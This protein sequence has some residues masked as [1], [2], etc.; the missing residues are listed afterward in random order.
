MSKVKFTFFMFIFISIFSLNAD[1]HDKEKR[2]PI[3]I[4][5]ALIDQCISSDSRPL[6]KEQMIRKRNMCIEVLKGL[7]LFVDYEDY[8]KNPKEFLDAYKLGL[9]FM[10]MLSE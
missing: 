3:E 4:E 7:E 8:K 5:Y 1:A 10:S 6:T 9:Y 2:Y